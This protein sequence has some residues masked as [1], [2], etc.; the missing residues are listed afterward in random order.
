MKEYWKLLVA[1]LIC[2]GGGWLSGLV[3]QESVLTWYPLLNKPSWTP[4]DA[5]FP[6]AWSILYIL[7]AIALYL[8]WSDP[9]VDSPLPLYL[10]GLQLF[11]NFSW[12]F[13]FFYLRS[14][15]AGL[16]DI[17]LLI[18]TLVPTVYLFW[19]Y[20]KLAGWLLVPYL[21]WTIYALFLN[22]FIWANN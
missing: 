16:L 1:L 18:I 9:K 12:S 3:T 5:L 20:R 6:I 22:A 7:M 11:F 17:T 14:P 19:S 8:I 15:L 2:L 21:G 4:P 10:F 13:L